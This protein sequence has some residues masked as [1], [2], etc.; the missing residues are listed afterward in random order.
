MRERAAA[1]LSQRLRP[2]SAGGAAAVLSSSASQKSRTGGLGSSLWGGVKG[3][4]GFG[5]SNGA[6]RP[7][8]V[9]SKGLDYR[10][11]ATGTSAATSDGG[12]SS[13]VKAVRFLS[14]NKVVSA[15][16][17]RTIRIWNYELNNVNAEHGL[18]AKLALFG[19]KSS[20]DAIAV[21]A[22][23]ARILSG[24]ADH[25]VGLWSSKKSEAP[26]PSENLL[27]SYTGP[28]KR[29][30]ISKPARTVPQRGPLQMMSGHTNPV[31]GVIFAPNDTTVA[32]SASWDHTMRTW[33]LPTGTLVDTRT[34][35]HP[36]LSLCALSQVNLIAT[37]STARHITAIDP[38]ASAVTV[39][40]MTL[41]GHVNAVS[42]LAADPSSAYGLV[43]GSHDGTCRIWDIRS[44]KPGT[45]RIA[46]SGGLVG[47]SVYVIPRT[48]Q[49]EEEKRR[50]GGEGVK[51]F[52]VAWNQDVGIVSAGEDRQVQINA[53]RP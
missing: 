45:G 46:E 11:A 7:A 50:V 5:A 33:D 17:D 10:F 20:V 29:R 42:S 52:S 35:S 25:T 12:H 16:A 38:R 21:D 44:V 47:E 40:A 31:S 36:L 13:S 32:H 2:A 30:R 34:T 19:H 8:S 26:Q 9:D 4:L 3:V 23:S 48:S 24:S 43:S 37:G 27:P 41:R 39:A 28:N 15:A 6:R 14:G 18:T 22:P 49:G 51:V 53:S 1:E